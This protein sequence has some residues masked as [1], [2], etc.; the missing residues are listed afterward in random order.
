MMSTVLRTVQ[1]KTRP[2]AYHHRA[3]QLMPREADNLGMRNWVTGQ[4]CEAVSAVVHAWLHRD[5]REAVAA[6]GG[7]PNE[8]LRWFL[9]RHADTPLARGLLDGIDFLDAAR[10]EGLEPEGD[11]RSARRALHC[12]VDILWHGSCRALGCRYRP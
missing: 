12:A 10:M 9:E 3:T 11:A 4:G 2:E 7:D 8:I 5:L 6:V 1:A